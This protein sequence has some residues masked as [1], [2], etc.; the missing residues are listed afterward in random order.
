ML[1]NLTKEVLEEP[2]P[3]DDGHVGVVLYD[4]AVWTLTE[5]LG[6]TKAPWTS[7]KEDGGAPFW[8]Y[9]E[10]CCLDIGRP[11]LQHLH[12]LADSR[13]GMPT[14]PDAFGDYNFLKK[15]LAR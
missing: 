5:H 7:I 15:N 11:I 8:W 1:S 14:A 3:L 10:H 6:T 9:H 12:S 13:P 4:L 2:D